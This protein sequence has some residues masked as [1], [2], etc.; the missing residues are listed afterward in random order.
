M[1]ISKIVTGCTL[2]AGLMVFASVQAQAQI[3]ASNNVAD[4][5]V[6]SNDVVIPIMVK[7]TVLS[8]NDKS[9]MQ[10]VSFSDKDLLNSVGAPAGST[11]AYWQGNIVVIFNN[12]VWQD[13]TTAGIASF[14]LTALSDK[15]TTGKNGSSKS[16]EVGTC[17]LA[18]FSSG[19]TNNVT[20]NADA[21]EATGTYAASVTTSV[22]NNNNNGGATIKFKTSDMSGVAFDRSSGTTLPVNAIVTGS[23]SGKGLLI[24]TNAP[25]VLTNAPPITVTTNTPPAA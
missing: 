14:V 12:A 13:L 3:I 20:N 9:K 1:K 6:A 21:F 25:P 23:T 5:I 8:L 16:A 19:D 24:T 18:F 10:K 15:T 7:A 11:L 4:S 22:G 17:S 2:A